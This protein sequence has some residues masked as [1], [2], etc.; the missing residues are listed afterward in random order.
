[1]ETESI[2][3]KLKEFH[4]KERAAFY[5]IYCRSIKPDCPWAVSPDVGPPFKQG[6]GNG[7]G[8]GM[9]WGPRRRKPPSFQK[10]PVLESLPTRKGHTWSGTEEI[11]SLQA[12]SGERNQ[13]LKREKKPSRKNEATEPDSVVTRCTVDNITGL[14]GPAL[15]GQIPAILLC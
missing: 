13:Q 1:M 3:Q 7:A 11:F 6:A 2:K 9:A 10:V 4:V 8:R 15:Q 5:F 14:E 12:F